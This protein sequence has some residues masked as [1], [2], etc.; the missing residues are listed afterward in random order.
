MLSSSS[1]KIDNPV[2]V[3]LIIYSA[4]LFI[5]SR[6]SLGV[7]LERSVFSLSGDESH[8]S[9]RVYLQLCFPEHTPVSQHS[10]PSQWPATSPDVRR[11]KMRG[12]DRCF[13]SPPG[14]FKGSVRYLPLMRTN[15]R[16]KWS[17]YTAS[18]NRD[19]TSG[20][21]TLQNGARDC[22]GSTVLITHNTHTHTHTHTHTIVTFPLSL[23]L[24]LSL[25][26]THT[27]NHTHIH[28]FLPSLS[29]SRS[30]ISVE[31]SM[32][33]ATSCYCGVPS[34][35][36]CLCSASTYQQLMHVWCLTGLY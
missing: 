28:T 16:P 35:N 32:E 18:H 34:I 29:F 31:A 17:Y 24:S 14:T 4:C 23:P 33:P 15:E 12:R 9:L 10:D 22:S 19:H 1:K 21:N 27:C 25:T 8:S 7:H 26:H 20:E 2:P 36:P 30:L 13:F 11:Y 3:S 6:L 5:A